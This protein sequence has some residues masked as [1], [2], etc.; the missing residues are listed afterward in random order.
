MAWRYAVGFN[1]DRTAHIV[2]R[3]AGVVESV[4]ANLG[5]RVKR[6]QVLAVISSATVSEMRSE[7]QGA[8][9]RREL[10]RTTYERENALWERRISPEQDVLQARQRLAIEHHGLAH[11]FAILLVDG[12]SVREDELASVLADGRPTSSGVLTRTL[13]S[14]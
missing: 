7:L 13:S 3:T 14:R 2:P 10:A 4:S 11:E 8:Q 5:Q 12:M 1:E 9:R 6:G